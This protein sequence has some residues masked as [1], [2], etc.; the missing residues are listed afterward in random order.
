M[1]EQLDQREKMPSVFLEILFRMPNVGVLRTERWLTL[2]SQLIK[3]QVRV[4]KEIWVCNR[5]TFQKNSNLPPI[6]D[7]QINIFKKRKSYLEQK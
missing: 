1:A 6:K 3:S 5:N 2:S 4:F 7:F